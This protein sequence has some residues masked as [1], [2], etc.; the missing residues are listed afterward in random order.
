VRLAVV[1]P[2]HDYRHL[3]AA[4]DSMLAQ[5]H[6]DWV[7]TVVVNHATG[8][9][10]ALDHLRGFVAEMVRSTP[11][12]K[13]HRIEFS[14]DTDPHQGV[15]QRKRTAFL[16]ACEP[17]AAGVVPEVLVEL[18]HDDLLTPNALARLAAA[19]RDHPDVGF[20]YSDCADFPDA[21]SLPAGARPTYHDPA[22]RA[23][24][25]LEGWKFRE[26]DANFDVTTAGCL[27]PSG[28]H[29]VPVMFPQS[30]LMMSLIFYA[31]NHVRAWRAS[32]YQELGGHDPA[33]AV[34]DDHELLIR[35][36][37]KTR[38][39]H[40]PAV[41]Y[42]YRVTGG[43]TWLANV[44]KIRQ[45]TYELQGKYLEA[46]VL[47]ECEL[48]GVPAYDLGGGIDPRPGW[49]PVDRR[50]KSLVHAASGVQVDLAG[51]WP[52]ADGGVGAFRAADLLEHLP[53][54]MHTM[55]ELH[56]CLRPGGW[57]LSSTPSTDGR[58]AFQDPTHVS[59]WN[60][61]AFWYYTRRQQA[62][63]VDNETI[64]FQEVHLSTGFPSDWH[65]DNNISYV[66]ANLVC[67]KGDSSDI[68]GQKGI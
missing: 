62:R 63:Y 21:S 29:L 61:N 9:A 44:S 22:C 17:D 47:R 32:V 12:D 11:V 3:R 28:R 46:L 7:W 51:R 57:L 15:G 10:A 55:S 48:A 31:P 58:G 1:T 4:W 52:W 41:L 36:Y 14:I 37:L 65:R 8:D 24:W 18:D 13:R 50:F 39:L 27:G 42:L 23:G 25:E 67:L 38:M 33:Y 56:R 40:V 26:S 68:P 30:A 66:T 2:T 64:R 45:L 16:R 6:E 43:N 34:C 54:K 35:T 19:F 20:V 53:D 49:I 60:Q 59:Y 5:T